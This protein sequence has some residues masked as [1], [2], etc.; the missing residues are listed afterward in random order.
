VINQ[1]PHPGGVILLV[2]LCYRDHDKLQTDELF[3]A[4]AAQCAGSNR[5]KV[6]LI[7]FLLLNL[8]DYWIQF[9]STDETPNI[10]QQT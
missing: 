4:Q 2:I 5:H 7:L 1:H 8:S 3:P 6:G 9:L 10:N